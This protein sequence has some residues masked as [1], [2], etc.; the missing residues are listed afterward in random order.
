MVK[1]KNTVYLTPIFHPKSD[2]PMM[3]R[4]DKND[5]VRI[6]DLVEVVGKRVGTKTARIIAGQRPENDV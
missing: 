5:E 3:V 6:F 2:W 1:E 4:I